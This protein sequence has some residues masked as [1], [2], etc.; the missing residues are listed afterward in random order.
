MRIGWF[1]V[2]IAFSVGLLAF[3]AKAADVDIV[4]EWQ[5]VSAE[6]TIGEQTFPTFN[7][8]TH[9]MIKILTDSHFAF[10]SKG[11]IRPR[12]SSYSLSTDDKITAFDNF[13]GGAGRYEFDGTTYTEHVEFSQ[14][15]NYEGSSLQFK[16][17]IEGD[18]L[19]QEG[20]YPIVALGLGEKDGYI[21]EVYQRIP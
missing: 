9:Q 13:G 19:V 16:V 6:L 1:R 18:M 3:T 17:T 15:P 2:F 8:D 5:L 4:G 12:F 21:K 11:P 20:R 7:P 10:V 14:Y